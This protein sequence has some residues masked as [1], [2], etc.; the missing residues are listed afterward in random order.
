MKDP[1]P[2]G[3]LLRLDLQPNNVLSHRASCPPPATVTPTFVLA[4]DPALSP[5]S[6]TC[7]QAPG[8]TVPKRRSSGDHPTTIDRQGCTAAGKP[9]SGEHEAQGGRDRR[10]QP[11]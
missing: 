6:G 8:L 11:R 1:A 2:A 5:R 10:G 9:R 3:D 7:A 4:S